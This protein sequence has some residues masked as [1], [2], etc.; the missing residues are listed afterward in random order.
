LKDS[1]KISIEM[2]HK[3][4]NFGRLLDPLCFEIVFGEDE[5][6]FE[7]QSIINPDDADNPLI[8]EAIRKL[9]SD[10]KRVIQN[11]I[12]TE[13]KNSSLSKSRILTLLK[14]G[15]GVLWEVTSAEKNA[16]IYELIEPE[17]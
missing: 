12:L 4:T 2:V 13:L 3:K 11:D 7:G 10:S 16:K 15:E 14:K 5:V 17:V 6:T 9:R 1:S 8:T